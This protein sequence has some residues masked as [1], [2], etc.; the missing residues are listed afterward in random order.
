MRACG[1][2]DLKDYPYIYF[3]YP[4]LGKLSR[5]VCVK[6]CPGKD[7]TGNI[8]CAKNSVFKDC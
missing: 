2:D 3:G 8:D 7:F 4:K 6:K 1:I 5:T